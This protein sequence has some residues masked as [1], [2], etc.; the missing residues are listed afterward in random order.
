[1]A[2]LNGRLGA[3]GGVVAFLA[4]SFGPTHSASAGCGDYLTL[5][6]GK[7]MTSSHDG[8]PMSPFASPCNGPNC[9]RSERPFLPPTPEFR[10]SPPTAKFAT[11]I[12]S[13][14][15]ERS[16]FGCWPVDETDRPLEGYKPTLLRPPQHV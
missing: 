7:S 1:M 4:L 16:G 10:L 5:D 12:A 13:V 11:L 2:N 9:H 8:K 6:H 15:A 3:I 14:Q